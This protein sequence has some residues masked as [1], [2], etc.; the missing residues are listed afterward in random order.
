MNL[1]LRNASR[2]TRLQRTI[3]SLCLLT[4]PIA[5]LASSKPQ[6]AASAS[7]APAIAFIHAAVIPMDANHILMDQTVIVSG[8]RIERVGPASQVKVPAN[9]RVI[10]ATG[11]YLLPGFTTAQAAPAAA[12]G[13]PGYLAPNS[14]VQQQLHSYVAAG[15][16]PFQALQTVTVDP[17]RAQHQAAECGTIA[18]GRRADLILLTANPL[19]EISN[20]QRVG[21][22][23]LAGLWHAQ[24]DLQLTHVN[25]IL[26]LQHERQV[27][28]VNGDG[29]MK[30]VLTTI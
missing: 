4:L 15:H 24:S 9:A 12:N 11:E 5:A 7:D 10:D 29:T 23:M 27:T 30:Y 19:A 1:S 28:Y 14:V 6:A 13:V 17:A 22:V 20:L 18:Q 25:A 26:Q 16:T 8:D 21:G 2:S 3:T